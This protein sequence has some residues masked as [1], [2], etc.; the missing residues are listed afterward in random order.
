MS[1]QKLNDETFPASLLL[2][3]DELDD[4]FLL[5][6][7]PGMMMVLETDPMISENRSPVMTMSNSSSGNYSLSTENENGSGSSSSSN[8]GQKIQRTSLSTTNKRINA[9]RDSKRSMKSVRGE[10]GATN[11]Q[12]L[13]KAG[14]T[15]STGGVPVN[16]A[17][18]KRAKSM[19]NLSHGSTTAIQQ[20]SHA[21]KRAKYGH[22]KSKVKQFI[23]ETVSQRRDRQT[24]VRHKSMPEQGTGHP[25]VEASNLERHLSVDELQTMLQEKSAENESL[26]RHLQF[27]ELQRQNTVEKFET[28]KRKL[29]AMR[30]EHSKREWNWDRENQQLTRLLETERERQLAL[31]SYLRYNNGAGPVPLNRRL[32]NTG[33]QTSP[34]LESFI[35]N[36]D[37][38]GID[39]DE[40]FGGDL[41]A[42]DPPPR[43]KRTLQFMLEEDGGVLEIEE[44]PDQEM[45]DVSP[46]ST[47]SPNCSQRTEIGAEASTMEPMSV[48]VGA[49]LSPGAASQ[50]S[51][52]DVCRECGTRKKKRKQKKIAKFASLFCIKKGE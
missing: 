16:S 52:P 17:Y 12:N 48:L 36:S 35:L 46:D 49:N 8:V 33:T 23:D 34:A 7:P 21:I 27:S 28:L 26:N 13:A 29:E 19:E 50:M 24:L 31:T 39:E 38:F 9:A 41:L 20:N 40:S 22:V 37:T 4:E 3:F 14:I 18:K 45:E 43:V 2:E 44:Q 47:R 1:Y 6:S 11:G 15:V 30:L 32:A 25:D 10:G 42:E 51:Q 5:V